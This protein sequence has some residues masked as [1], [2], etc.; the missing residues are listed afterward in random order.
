[1][2]ENYLGSEITV[3]HFKLSTNTISVTEAKL[4][5]EMDN[6]AQLRSPGAVVRV[7]SHFV[8]EDYCDEYEMMA[9]VN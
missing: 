6:I 5:N 8:L 2:N 9:M 7:R 1:M 3:R 4:A